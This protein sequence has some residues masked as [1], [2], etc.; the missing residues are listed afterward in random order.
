[1][2]KQFNAFASTH[3]IKSLLCIGA[4]VLLT[5]CGGN[6]DA[7]IEQ[8]S[9]TAASLATDAGAAA[10]AAA[11]AAAVEPITEAA[12]A[13][14]NEAASAASNGAATGTEP[15]RTANTADAT[16]Q[17]PAVTTQEFNLTGYDSSSLQAQTG[18]ENASANA[19]APIKQ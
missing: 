14:S 4:A 11:P 17:A 16:T 15:A 1:M 5:A 12:P 2:K 18:Q 9:A 19:L 7:G 13:A 6:T 8:P 3:R 10:S